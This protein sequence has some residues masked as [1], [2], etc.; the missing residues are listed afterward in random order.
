[1]AFAVPLLVGS[2]AGVGAVGPVAATAGLFGSAG[3]FSLG[4]ALSTIGTATSLFG[5]L[6]SMRGSQ[7]QAQS[8]AQAARYNAAVAANN[9]TI[10]KQNSAW[11]AQHGQ[12]ETAAALAKNRAEAGAIQAN[13]GASGVDIGSESALDVRSSA[14]ETGQLSAIDIR[15]KAARQ[16]YGYDI[17]AQDFQNQSQLDKA[18]AR[19]DLA[20]G[21]INASSTLLSGISSASSGYSD[22]LDKRSL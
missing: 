2:A 3:A 12:Q 10:A 19:N 6:T 14:K 4:T 18:Q 7:Q 20:A 16:A 17:E 11:A 1:M 13:Q 15:T 9:A 8:S 21:D 22:Y 5:T